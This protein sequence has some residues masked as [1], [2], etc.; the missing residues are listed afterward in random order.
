MPTHGP[1]ERG[2]ADGYF[3]GRGSEAVEGWMPD[4]VDGNGEGVLADDLPQ[5]PGGPGLDHEQLEMR[6]LLRTVLTIVVVAN[7]LGYLIA[8]SIGWFAR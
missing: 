3:M 2:I 6:V 7:V 5:L 8:Y 1:T 4:G